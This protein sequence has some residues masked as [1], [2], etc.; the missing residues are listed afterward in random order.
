MNLINETNY[1]SSS[2]KCQKLKINKKDINQGLVSKLN[3]KRDSNFSNG[4]QRFSLLSS[5]ANQVT[6]VST[7]RGNHNYLSAD[8]ILKD[9]NKISFNLLGKL[10]AENIEKVIE[11]KLDAFDMLESLDN[12]N[13]N[14]VPKLDFSD[15]F[16]N[17]RNTS[18]KVMVV[19]GL[20]TSS[21]SCSSMLDSNNSLESSSK[22]EKNDHEQKRN[23]QHRHKIHLKNKEEEKSKKNNKKKLTKYQSLDYYN[24]CKNNQK[25]DDL[26]SGYS[27]LF[28]NM[29]MD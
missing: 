15:I 29:Y 19:K 6:D 22:E 1:Q 4:L 23:H 28:K 10:N 7:N 8:R 12:Q 9:K 25:I 14:F 18:V 2:S 21:Y 5:I 13:L 16:S 3:P 26:Y 11:K 27:D 24:N 20:S 17:Y